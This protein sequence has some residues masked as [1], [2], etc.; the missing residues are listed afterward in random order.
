MILAGIIEEVR[1]AADALTGAAG[2]VSA[3]A[4]SL[5]QSASEQASSVEQ[6]TASIDMISASI[7]ESMLPPQSTSP[8]LRPAN[9]AG[10]FSMAAS[11]AAGAPAKPSLTLKRRL[12]ATPEKVFA[13]W[14]QPVATSHVS[15]V[16]ASSSADIRFQT[17]R[18]V[19]PVR[20][21]SLLSPL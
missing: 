10:N 12:N 19:G 21:N 6:T 5:S 16:H 2:Q 17:S 8:T 15:V 13:A 1:A 3:T 20:F 14:T 4:Q 7:S 11:A 18:S 9:C